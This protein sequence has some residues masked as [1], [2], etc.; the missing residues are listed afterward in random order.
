MHIANDNF[1][2]SSSSIDLSSNWTSEAMPLEHIVQFTIQ[3]VFT[4]TMTGCFY[5]ECSSE[6]FDLRKSNK[7]PT[8]WTKIEGS[9][10]NITEGGDHT[11]NV[12]DVG[13][14]WV[15]IQWENTSSSG[16]LSSAQINAK[17]M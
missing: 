11:W 7:T 8:K 3:L 1:F 6:S 17:G 10:Q 4:G 9:T 16:T 15:R 5:L 12:E 14:A 13:F 2:E